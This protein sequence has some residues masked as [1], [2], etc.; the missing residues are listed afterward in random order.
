MTN[1]INK[2]IK[3][4]GIPT[5]SPQEAKDRNMFGPLYHG[6]TPEALNAILEEGFK[7]EGVEQ[8]NGYELSNYGPLSI[9]APIHHLGYGVYLTTTRSI[10]KKFNGGTEKGLKPF[11]LDSRNI[12]QINFASENTMMKWWIK[13]GYNMQPI[14][15]YYEPGIEAKR[16]EATKNLTNTLKSRC[17]AVWFKGK[18]LFRLLDGDQIC[19]Y[20][21]ELIY[22]VDQKLA[23]GLEIG[24]K[25][26]INPQVNL[27]EFSEWEKVPGYGPAGGG[28]FWGVIIGKRNISDELQ[29]K[30]NYKSKTFYEIK[31][32]KGGKSLNVQEHEI[33]PYSKL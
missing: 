33:I 10:A 16:I 15:N 6:T 26:Q 32:N 12:E 19:I 1:I 30:N 2:L 11:F 20:K 7:I 23:Q 17:D 24:A 8:R 28:K 22:M 14:S 25:V 3:L 5:I 29:Q 13:N 9:P 31:W 27:N 18:G 4:S 21:P